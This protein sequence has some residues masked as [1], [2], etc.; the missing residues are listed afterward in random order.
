MRMLDLPEKKHTRTPKEVWLKIKRDYMAGLGSCRELAEKYGVTATAVQNRCKRESWRSEMT[1]L[2]SAVTKE[3]TKIIAKRTGDI[4]ELREHTIRRTCEDGELFRSVMLDFLTAIDKGD[5][6][7]LKKLAEIYRI[8]SDQPRKVLG[9]GQEPMR[10][11]N[12]LINTNFTPREIR[13]VEAK[14]IDV[15]TEED[16]F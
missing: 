5:I 12:W 6:S 14:A 15:E 7:G 1:K 16:P 2:E 8:T 4:M 10:Q 3:T 9:L 13:D 11:T